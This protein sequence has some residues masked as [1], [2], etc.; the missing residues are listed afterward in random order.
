MSI[1]SIGH[2][3]EWR[4]HERNGEWHAWV[5][6]IQTTGS[7]PQHRHKVVEVQAGSV[8]PLEAPEAYAEV[9]R[10]IFANDGTVR[11]WSPQHS[12]TPRQ[13]GQPSRLAGW[14]G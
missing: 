1:G 4:L 11:R 7:P 12:G 9:P 2:L 5:S 10:R 3:L 8:S 14:P 6:W 13:P